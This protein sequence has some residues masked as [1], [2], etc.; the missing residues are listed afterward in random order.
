MKKALVIDDEEGLRLVI[1]ELLNMWDI[2]AHGMEDSEQALDFVNRQS[3]DIDYFFIDVNLPNI[4]GKELYH[5]LSA[6]FPNAVYVFMSGFAQDHD[7]IDLPKEGHFEFL[8]KPFTM[9][10]LQKL[11]EKLVR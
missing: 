5:Q 6:R 10:Q 2:E 11:M 7:Q 3:G 8:K 9:A 4:S 1:V